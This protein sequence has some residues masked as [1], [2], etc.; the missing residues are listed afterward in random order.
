M[1]VTPFE[2]ESIKKCGTGEL[3]AEGKKSISREPYL[4]ATTTESTT[5]A[6]G[7]TE[8]RGEVVLTKPGGEVVGSVAGQYVGDPARKERRLAAKSKPIEKLVGEDIYVLAAGFQ[9]LEPNNLYCYQIVDNGVA[10]TELAPMSTAPKPG[11]KNPI[12]FIAVGDIG[13][14]GDAQKA[15]AQ[16][17]TEKPFELIL[18]LG[19]L[20]YNSGTAQEIHR[21]FF[22]I[23]ANILRFVPVFP[24]IG[25]H[26]R[27]TREGGPYFEAFVLPQPERYY[28]FDWGDVHF[29][30]ID[31]TQRDSAQIAWLEKD[32]AAT[33][34]RWK[35]VFGHHPMYTNALRG[36]QQWIRRA[37]S[38]IFT[39]HQVDM[40]ITGHEHQYE[41]FR[42]GNVN[43]IVSG[44]GGGQLTRFFGLYYSL[45]KAAK[46][47]YLY[48]EA[49]NQMLT[50]KAIDIEGKE[51]ETLELKKT[52]DDAKPDVKVNDKPENK[53]TPI[54]PETKTTPDEKLH[55][56]PDDDKDEPH[57]PPVKIP[58]APD[59][60][61]PPAV[62]EQQAPPASSTTEPKAK[63][64]PAKPTPAA[65]TR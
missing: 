56:E 33:K 62:K 19:D 54:A 16:R 9:K 55:D 65:A 11:S 28:S 31:T 52:S 3:T 36:P 63:A 25:N 57:Q 2:H 27:R 60:P 6:W 59:K 37:Y 4:Q 53:Q 8:G 44:G 17:M 43:Y 5:I 47:H 35:V 45:K 21:K 50:M 41:R 22:Q 58:S 30:A 24:A 64:A 42:V 7:S 26:E 61:T 29:V 38:K 46:H 15:I 10:L 49:T 51:I 20:A 32:L 14:G 39:D 1:V 48:L 12:R 23:Y 18:V 34:Q 40:V 13:T